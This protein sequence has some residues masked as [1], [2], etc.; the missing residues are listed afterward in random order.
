MPSISVSPPGLELVAYFSFKEPAL[1]YVRNKLNTN[2]SSVL[3]KVIGVNNLK[4]MIEAELRD[5]FIDTY[6]PIGI[7]SQEYKREVLDEVPLYVFS[8]TSKTGKVTFIKCPLS[9]VSDYSLTSDIL[10]V[11]KLLVI[12]LKKLPTGLNTV[13]IFQELSD[14]VY[15]RFGVRPQ[16]KEVSVGDPEN[17]TREDY[18]NREAIRTSTITV[19][20]SNSVMLSEI[21]LKYN[22]LV[23]RLSDLNISLG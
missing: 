11:N 3:L 20:K 23:G 5:P 15:D 8:H 6:N 18:E 19:K 10:Y 14:L 16:I 22:Q 4:S 12:D 1:T 2:E 13:V 21:T 7:S 9:Y 17:T